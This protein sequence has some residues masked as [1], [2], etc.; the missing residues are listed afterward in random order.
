MY[1]QMRPKIYTKQVWIEYECRQRTNPI[2]ITFATNCES[3]GYSPETRNAK[4]QKFDALLKAWDVKMCRAML[5][6]RFIDRYHQRPSGYLFR[7]HCDT[8]LHYHGIFDIKECDFDEFCGQAEKIWGEIIPNGTIDIQRVD[9]TRK[10]AQY[11]LKDQ[12]DFTLCEED[13]YVMIPCVPKK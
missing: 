12:S 4:I 9:D 5:G 1:Y 3:T 7:E 11:V 6:R 8:N 10:V 2:F 13:G